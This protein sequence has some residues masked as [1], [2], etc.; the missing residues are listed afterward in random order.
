MENHKIKKVCEK[1]YFFG[2]RSQLRVRKVLT[3]YNVAQRQ[4]P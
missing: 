1:P 3:P 2:S 4:Y